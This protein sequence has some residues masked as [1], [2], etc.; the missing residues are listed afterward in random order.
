MAED[1]DAAQVDDLG[2]L[3]GF[4][5]A[6]NEMELMVNFLTSRRELI[7]RTLDSRRDIDVEAGY[8]YKI[9]LEQYA[10]L[11]EREGIAAR[12]V[13]IFPEECWKE[14]PKIY[15]TED[16]KEHPFEER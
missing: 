8:P 4:D 1:K 13:S 12:V 11:Y 3:T 9:G 2:N 10:R 15:E 16:S 7:D 14:E 5:L 6:A